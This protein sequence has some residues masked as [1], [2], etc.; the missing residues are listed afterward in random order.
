MMREHEQKE[1]IRDDAIYNPIE[2]KWEKRSRYMDDNTENS[3]SVADSVWDAVKKMTAF[4]GEKR[5]ELP[6][7]NWKRPG[8]PGN[9]L[10]IQIIIAIILLAIAAM[11]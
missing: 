8:K 6:V 11:R 2:G 5:M 7:R 9:L 1:M 4:S 3:E 10:I